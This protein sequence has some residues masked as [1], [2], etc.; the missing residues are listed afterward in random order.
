MQGFEPETPIWEIPAQKTQSP[1]R[2]S[3]IFFFDTREI[4]GG[5]TA[6]LQLVHMFR[7][8]GSIAHARPL[9]SS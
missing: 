6:Q 2:V 4:P 8:Q 5:L 7:T 3:T 1:L 9:P